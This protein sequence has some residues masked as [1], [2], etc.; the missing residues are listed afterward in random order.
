MKK[1]QSSPVYVFII[2]ILTGVANIIPGLSGGTVMAISGLF[3]KI[4]VNIKIL[5]RFKIRSREYYKSM[6]FILLMSFGVLA[7]IF[8]F[9]FVI[10]ALFEN[11]F[12]RQMYAVIIVLVTISAYGYYNEFK[13][14]IRKSSI[15]FI[16][17]LLIPVGIALAGKY[18][19]YQFTDIGFAM[20]LI[21][22]F[23]S[24]VTM[25]LPGI[26]GSL[27]LVIIGVY[28]EF[29]EAI[30]EFNVPELLMIGLGVITGI[31]VATTV[32]SNAYENHREGVNVAIFG[33]IISS[34]AAIVVYLV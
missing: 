21:A 16:I 34:I 33:A 19:T 18:T 9:A 4:V 1:H 23:L 3:E 5:T 11:G 7:G 24:S 30:T 32:L 29:T 14:K 20:F 22:G 28:S 27:L 8:G 26:S 25:I 6:M 2:G 12:E 15:T 17:S 13:P 10:D 31:V